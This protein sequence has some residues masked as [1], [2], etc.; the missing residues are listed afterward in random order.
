M[1][2]VNVCI[3]VL[4]RY[5]M[6]R[7]AL[8]SLQR[9]T[10]TPEK[11]AIIDNGQD[12]EALRDAVL[13]MFS[14][15]ILDVYT[16]KEPMGCAESWNWF[17]RNVSEE[18]VIANDDIEF[19][20]QSLEKLVE[21]K[22]GF[23]MAAEAGYSCFLLRDSMVEAIGYFDETISPGYA[24]YEDED[25]ACRMIQAKIPYTAVETGVIH[26][27]SMTLK[28]GSHDDVLDHH[29]KFRIAQKNFVKKWGAMPDV[30]KGTLGR[31]ELWLTPDAK[32]RG[33]RVEH[34]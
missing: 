12:A 30:V 22:E 21:A 15:S 29:R 9:S 25:H 3:P 17:T 31:G 20:P 27:H 28:A 23:V 11:I 1:R 14:T 13:G 5:D 32:A 33:L 24:Y 8:E 6:L 10:I 26:H 18:R 7:K 19:A 4:N 34:V 16:P 2:S